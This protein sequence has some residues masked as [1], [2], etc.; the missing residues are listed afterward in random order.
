MR[1]NPASSNN[2][3]LVSCFAITKED[4]GLISTSGGNISFFDMKTFKVIL[5]LKRNLDPILR[6]Y[7][8]TCCGGVGF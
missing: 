8:A 7:C 6:I 5:Y 3:E 2:G 1:N 4:L